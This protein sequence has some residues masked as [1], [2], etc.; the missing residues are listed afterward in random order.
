M[1]RCFVGIVGRAPHH[2]YNRISGTF[3]TDTL[4][5]VV[6]SYGGYKYAQ[7]FVDKDLDFVYVVPMK[8]NT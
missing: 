4:C 2:R 5:G 8:E 3:Y 1:H 6:E 7:V